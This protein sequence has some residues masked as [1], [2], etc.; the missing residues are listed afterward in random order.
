MP[1]PL[2]RWPLDLQSKGLAPVSHSLRYNPGRQPIQGHDGVTDRRDLCRSLTG[3]AVFQA[4]Q[5]R[6]ENKGAVSQS[7]HTQLQPW[8]GYCPCLSLAFVPAGT[9]LVSSPGNGSA[10]VAYLL[11]SI[12]GLQLNLA[13]PLVLSMRIRLFQTKLRIC[14]YREVSI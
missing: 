1:G 8:L 6:T 10:V 11:M 13:L 14:V 2:C 12:A 3:Q 4:H 7:A 5:H 9:G